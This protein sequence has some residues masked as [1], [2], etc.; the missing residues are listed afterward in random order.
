M[1]EET[2]QAVVEENNQSTPTDETTLT[3]QSP[4][5]D[6]VEPEQAADTENSESSEPSEPADESE[7]QREVKR[8]P[9]VER[10]FD[11]MTKKMAE[12]SKQA[13]PQV[14]NYLPSEMPKIEPGMEYDADQLDQLMNQ[15]A[16]AIAQATNAQLVAQLQARETVSSYI[17]N[18]TEDMSELRSMSPLLNP[19][20]EDYDE[21]LEAAIVEEF[22]GRNP[23][24]VDGQYNPNVRLDLRLKDV[25]QKHLK[26][27]ERYRTR[28]QVESSRDLKAAADSAVI[29]PA[30]G[31]QSHDDNSLEALK[32]KLADFK[33]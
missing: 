25:A 18:L 11:Q 28:G 7:E 10:R 27:V 4:N 16:Q 19:S 22:E 1:D 21:D 15:K 13:Q 29:P 9:R 12:I 3:E 20:S 32:E 23:I 24:D 6:S 2:T 8:Q 33:F 30:G 31:V 17:N 26:N 5:E 14:A